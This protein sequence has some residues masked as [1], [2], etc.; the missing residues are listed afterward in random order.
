MADRPE[1]SVKR[2]H[3]KAALGNSQSGFFVSPIFSPKDKE[4]PTQI[5][6]V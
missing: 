2:S 5:E 4:S 6:S 3:E 1:P